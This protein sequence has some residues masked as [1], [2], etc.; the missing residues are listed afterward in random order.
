MIAAGGPLVVSAKTL[1]SA[2]LVAVD[3][4]DPRGLPLPRWSAGSH[5]NLVLA[6]GLVRPYSLCG[7]TDDRR[8]WRILVRRHAGSRGASAHIH[9][10]LKA[11]DR[12]RH[13]GVVPGLVLGRADRYRFLAGGAGIAPLIPLARLAASARA[14]W[15]LTVFGR[16]A[17]AVAG[18]DEIGDLRPAITT[19][20]E[21]RRALT[22]TIEGLEPGSAVYACGPGPFVDA[23]ENA[24]AGRPDLALFREPFDAP[25]ADPGAAMEIVL[26]RSG[27]S[28]SVPAGTSLNEGLRA[29]GVSVPVACGAGFC[30][31]CAVGVVEG[32]PDHRDRLL[33]P[34]RRARGDVILTCVSRSRTPRLVLDL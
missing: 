15:S 4:C 17:L 31:A 16:D 11:G 21:A 28:F 30:G 3:L 34:S 10:S 27:L 18:W 12:L 5:V 25:A 22:G 7:R 2:S 29:V 6:S 33:S 13:L 14:A 20:P 9:D 26:A 32:V 23:V 1:V 19:A 8:V 24:I